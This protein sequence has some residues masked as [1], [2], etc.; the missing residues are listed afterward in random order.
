ME[1]LLKSL[2][3]KASEIAQSRQAKTVTASHL[4]ACVLEEETMDFL[5]DVVASAPD[6]AA[7]EDQPTKPKRRRK[8]AAEDGEAGAASPTEKSGKARASRAKKPKQETE[9]EEGE[10]ASSPAPR[11]R[12]GK[13]AASAEAADLNNI[14]WGPMSEDVMA[15]LQ[16]QYPVMQEDD[17]VGSVTAEAPAE[18]NK[19]TLEQLPQQHEILERAPIS[20]LG[21]LE[22]LK[23]GAVA[24][25]AVD[26][27][28]LQGGSK[29]GKVSLRSKHPLSLKTGGGNSSGGR[30]ADFEAS[31][32]VMS[33]AEPGSSSAVNLEVKKEE[34]MSNLGDGQVTMDSI[35]KEKSEGADTENVTLFPGGMSLNHYAAAADSNYDDDY[36]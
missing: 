2:C 19:A 6:L 32:A 13:A 28:P 22:T 7:Q 36:D 24:A 16:V 3:E 14:D 1:V 35:C 27:K 20:N 30:S 17:I 10:P 11:K 12:K 34:G 23:S 5:K 8:A 21:Q 4:K 18:M 15:A 26:T 25:P 29:S 33:E 31:S 9:G